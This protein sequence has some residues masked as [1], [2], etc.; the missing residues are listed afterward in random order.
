MR[1]RQSQNRLLEKWLADYWRLE[2]GV[3]PRLPDRKG[4]WRCWLR[5]FRRY[6]CT[7]TPD[8]VVVDL[9]NVKHRHIVSHVFAA[10]RKGHS[11]V[12]H[13]RRDEGPRRDPPT[14]PTRQCARELIRRDDLG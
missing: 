14:R 1:R 9:D 8:L 4:R 13:I 2:R 7:L 10:R 11:R 6:A 12:L 5:P 3:N